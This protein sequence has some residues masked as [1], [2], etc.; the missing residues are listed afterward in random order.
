[1]KTSFPSIDELDFEKGTGLIPAIVQDA[2]SGNVLMLGYMDS[3][4]Y[5]KTLQENRVTFYSRSKKR[6]WTKG[7][8]SGNWLHLIDIRIDC[9]ADTLLIRVRPDGPVCHRGTTSCFDKE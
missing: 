1:M 4:A 3:E 2:T 9:D 8:T 7:E 6:L 5:T